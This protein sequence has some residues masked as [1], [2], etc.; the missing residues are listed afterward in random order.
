MK[1]IPFAKALRSA[2]DA[3]AELHALANGQLKLYIKIL[4]FI[5]LKIINCG[6][7]NPNL[8]YITIFSLLLSAEKKR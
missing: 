5:A 1:Y 3:F 8:D 7:L 2:N 4:G 6:F